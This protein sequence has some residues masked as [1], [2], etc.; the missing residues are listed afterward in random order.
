[1]DT[2]IEIDTGNARDLDTQGTGWFIGFSPWALQSLGALRH[3]PKE[4]PVKGLCVK[5]Y[6]HPSGHDSGNGKP[7]SEGRTVSVLVTEGAEFRIDF[8]RSA[9]FTGGTVRTVVLQREGDFAAWGPGLFHRW[10]CVRRAVIA[11][12]RWDPGQ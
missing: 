12:V 8:S 10:R 9:D 1:M 3:V 11:T 5:W 7:R 6:E 4:Q 2:A